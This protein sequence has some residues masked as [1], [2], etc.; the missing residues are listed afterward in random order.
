FEDIND[1][2]TA[3]T[4]TNCNL[5]LP[6]SSLPVLEGNKFYFHEVI[7]FVLIDESFGEIGKIAQILEYPNQAL[8]Q[9]FYKEKEVLI[10]INDRFIVSVDREK[11]EIKMN[12]PDGLIQVY[13]E[14]E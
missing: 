3:A 14:D 8:F 6:L 4:L 1:V 9:I 12:L 7:D 13:T 5:Y 11:K 10:P 2:E